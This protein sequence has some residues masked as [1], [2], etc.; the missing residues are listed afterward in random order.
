VNTGNAVYHIVVS[1]PQ[2]FRRTKD[3]V[4]IVCDGQPV[5]GVRVPIFKDGMVHE[6][7]V[8]L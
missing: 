1:K 8:S 4:A 2:G 6:V 5:P 7:K 3:G